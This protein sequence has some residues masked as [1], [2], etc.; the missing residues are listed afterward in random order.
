[1]VDHYQD[2]AMLSHTLAHRSSFIR[3]LT[4]SYPVCPTSW[5]SPSTAI[6]GRRWCHVCEDSSSMASTTSESQAVAINLKQKDALRSNETQFKFVPNLH[7]HGFLFIS[8]LREH[9]NTALKMYVGSEAEIPNNRTTWNTGLYKTRTVGSVHGHVTCHVTRRCPLRPTR[10]RGV[11]CRVALFPRVG[12]EQAWLL[13]L[14]NWASGSVGLIISSVGTGVPGP[15][16]GL[17][18]I[19]PT[20]F[21][22]HG[23][24][25]KTK[26]HK[27]RRRAVIF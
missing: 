11:G 2:T 13:F 25:T 19:T 3:T 22:R 17:R 16:R 9:R 8:E 5:S 18:T 4:D 14:L 20:H 15:C 12:E 24:E 6:V 7:Q 27:T 21:G 23:D 1:M 26:Q 10:C